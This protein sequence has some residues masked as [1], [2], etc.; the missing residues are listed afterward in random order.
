MFEKVF[1]LK[2]QLFLEKH[3][4]TLAPITKNKSI[5]HDVTK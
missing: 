4:F 5:T 1:L 3:L 2:K